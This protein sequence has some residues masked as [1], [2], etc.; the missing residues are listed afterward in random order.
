[1]LE[2]EMYDLLVGLGRGVVKTSISCFVGAGVGLVTFGSLVSDTD[3]IWLRHGPPPEM[4]L[5]IGAGMLSA[6]AMMIGLFFIPWNGKP[7]QDAIEKGEP[8]DV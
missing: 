3:D 4:F 2:A 7:S 1:V 8:L 5:A 6:G